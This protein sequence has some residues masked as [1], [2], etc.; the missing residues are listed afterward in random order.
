LIGTEGK[1]PK[2]ILTETGYAKGSLSSTD[3]QTKDVGEVYGVLLSETVNDSWKPDNLI[4]IR[5]S[6]EKSE[7]DPKG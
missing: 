4:V 6:A 2:K 5:G 1:T 3:F 7:F